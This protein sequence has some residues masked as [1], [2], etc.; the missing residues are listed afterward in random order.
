MIEHEITVDGKKTKVLIRTQGTSTMKWKHP[1][2]PG[3][4][5]RAAKR[6]LEFEESEQN[7][8]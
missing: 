2:T 8:T 1:M 3:E 6:A 7:K 4:R 5:L